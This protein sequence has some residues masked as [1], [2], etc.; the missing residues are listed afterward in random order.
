MSRHRE[1]DGRGVWSSHPCADPRRLN[2]TAFTEV[3]ALM[4]WDERLARAFRRASDE[5]IAAGSPG[6]PMGSTD[7]RK[8]FAPP[9]EAKQPTTMER[10]G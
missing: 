5:Y 10:E 6:V 8:H 2:A 1:W 3:L 4:H 9:V 7:Y